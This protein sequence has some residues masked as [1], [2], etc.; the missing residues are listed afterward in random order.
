M[1]CRLV[2]LAHKSIQFRK[3]YVT[4]KKK[5]LQASFVA[6]T[7][8]DCGASLKHRLRCLEETLLFGSQ[9]TAS[10][11]STWFSTHSVSHITTVL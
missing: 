8:G 2:V 11:Y 10:L 1:D 4:D 3:V 5:T 9:Y 6:Q 7:V